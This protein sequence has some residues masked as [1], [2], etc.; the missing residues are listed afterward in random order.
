MHGHL[1]NVALLVANNAYLWAKSLSHYNPYDYAL[2]SN[3][4]DIANFL[5]DISERL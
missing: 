5:L 3:N 1:N 2:Q 4:Q